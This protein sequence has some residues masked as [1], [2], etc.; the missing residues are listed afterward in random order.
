MLAG[1]PEFDP[2]VVGIVS[3]EVGGTDRLT[4]SGAQWPVSLAYSNLGT[5][6]PSEISCLNKKM[7]REMAQWL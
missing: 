5:P 6:V 2:Y 4:A 3:P 1:G 7:F